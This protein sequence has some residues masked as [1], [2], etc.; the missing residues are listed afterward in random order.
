MSHGVKYIIKFSIFRNIRNFI[1]HSGLLGLVLFSTSVNAITQE[2]VDSYK[3]LA[4][5]GDGY[6][7]VIVGQLYTFGLGVKTDK[8]AATRYFKKAQSQGDADTQYRIGLIF[9][10]GILGETNYK[11]ALLWFKKSAKQKHVDSMYQVGRYYQEGFSV[12]P[13]T[14]RAYY[15]LKKAADKGNIKAAYEVGML[16]RY[17]KSVLNYEAAAF[18]LNKASFTSHVSAT[19][20]L[21]LLHYYGLGV[22]KDKEKAFELFLDASGYYHGNS[23]YYLAVSAVNGEGTERSYSDAYYYLLRAQQ[24]SIEDK[25]SLQSFLKEKLDAQ[26]L[27]NA[28]IRLQEESSI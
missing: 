4:D 26:A 15:W 25:F 20:E 22:P 16:S 1:I 10:T 12:D 5:Q 24:Y 3:R 8:E 11:E 23:F 19:Y 6:Y 14:K 13:N 9:D 2:E 21:G 17:E 27:I 7:Q 18:Y 28:H